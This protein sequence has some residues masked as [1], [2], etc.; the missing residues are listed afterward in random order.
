M[1]DDIPIVYY[2]QEQGMH[3]NGDIYNREA[4]WPS[5]YQNT[6]TVRLIAKLNTLRQ[7]MIKMDNTCLMQRTSILS[8]TATGIAIQK[9]SVI[10][11]ITN[12]GLPVRDWRSSCGVA[13]FGVLSAAKY[14]HPCLYSLQAQ[15]H[16]H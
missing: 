14:Q 5:G 2:G 15:R 16:N 12:I 6:A 11:I 4:L 7:W 3:G 8:S 9:G 1:T 13:D 10:S